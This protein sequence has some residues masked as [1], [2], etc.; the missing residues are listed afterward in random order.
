M[1]DKICGTNGKWGG[2]KREKMNMGVEINPEWGN[3]NE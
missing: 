3:K 1:K 2:I